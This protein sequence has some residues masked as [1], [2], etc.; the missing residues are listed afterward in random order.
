MRKR[1]VYE[2]ISVEDYDQQFKAANLAQMHCAR[3]VKLFPT[4]I[5][6]AYGYGMVWISSE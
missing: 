2:S 4:D 3:R 1:I 5:G 6:D